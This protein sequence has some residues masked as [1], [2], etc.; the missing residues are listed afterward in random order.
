MKIWKASDQLQPLPRWG[1]KFGEL[2][3]TNK[4]VIGAHLDPLNWTSDYISALKVAVP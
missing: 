3:S 1:L 4:K 2:R